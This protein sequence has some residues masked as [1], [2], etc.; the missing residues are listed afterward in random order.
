MNIKRFTKDLVRP[1]KYRLILSA[2]YEHVHVYKLTGRKYTYNETVN[3][4]IFQQIAIGVG[5]GNKMSNKAK[6]NMIQQLKL[7]CEVA[8][9]TNQIRRI[10]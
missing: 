6:M 5:I 9:I 3:I 2:D 7:N 1:N 10:K 4:S 8:S